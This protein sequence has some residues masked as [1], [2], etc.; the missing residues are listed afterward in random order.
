MRG[1]L[2]GAGRGLV[3]HGK[4]HP[5]DPGAPGRLPCACLSIW[6]ASL[7]PL[8]CPA[9]SPGQRHCGHCASA[10]GKWLSAWLT[11]AN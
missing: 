10:G 11:I 3:R 6:V 5:V 2:G 1:R 4:R 8:P 7:Q 9:G